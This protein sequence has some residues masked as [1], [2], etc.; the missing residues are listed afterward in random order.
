MQHPFATEYFGQIFI[1]TACRNL[2]SG[3]TSRKCKSYETAAELWSALESFL[4][5]GKLGAKDKEF[6][7]LWVEMDEPLAAITEYR[8]LHS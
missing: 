3:P 4:G 7:M 8:Y 2:D 1:R 5:S 6:K